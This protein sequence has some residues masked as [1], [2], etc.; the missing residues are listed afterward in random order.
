MS[1]EGRH[2]IVT[3]GGTGVGRAIA[4][5]FARAGAKVTIMGRREEPL[6]EVAAQHK[7]IGWVICD[8]TDPTSVTGAFKQACGLNGPVSVVLANAGAAESTPFHRMTPEQLQAMLAVNLG[9]VVNVWQAALPDMKAEGWGRLIAVASTAGL[10][11]YA[12]VSGYSAAKHAVVGLTRSLALELGDCG[13]TANAICP[14]FIETPLLERSIVNIME[15]TGMDEAKARASL[16]SANPQGR[17]IQTDE[18]AGAALWLCS[19]AARS[20]NGHALSISGGEI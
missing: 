3:G 17:F 19:D 9:G 10:K 13:V 20:V 8:V 16:V 6:R 2:I 12:Y 14:G 7:F 18:V 5:T 11:G 4:E 15:K 1:V